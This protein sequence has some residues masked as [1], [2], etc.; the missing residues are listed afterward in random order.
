MRA[1]ESQGKKQPGRAKE[2]A[3]PLEATFLDP[4]WVETV[5]F[6]KNSAGPAALSILLVIVFAR[7]VKGLHEAH[8][9]S[10]HDQHQSHLGTIDNLHKSHVASLTDAFSKALEEKNK[11]V[12]R[13]M[14]YIKTL[15]EEKTS[16]R[17]VAGEK[18]PRNP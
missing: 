16:L 11:E 15:Q 18:Q 9:K 13:L 7:Y 3:A 4:F 10:I 1:K 12:E 5:T 14:D 2:R 17:K 6:L 8:I